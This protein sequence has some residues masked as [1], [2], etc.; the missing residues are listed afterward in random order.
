MADRDSTAL[1][2]LYSRHGQALFSYLLR[3]AGDRGVAEEILQDTLLAAWR[4]AG[5]FEGRSAV[6][7]WLFGI[8]RRQTHNRLRGKRLEWADL[9][10]AADMSSGDPGPEAAAL[11]GA[12][13]EAI[14]AAMGRI[15]SVH[16]EVLGLAFV[17][18]M[19]Y[20]EIAKI[21]AIPVGTVKSR[22]SHARR[23]LAAE[24]KEKR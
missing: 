19:A 21:L 16:A 1:A 24:L 7:T 10:E 17:D 14:V 12:D 4:S 20:V 15:S 18:G 11:A 5:G 13:R 23:A 6:R 2:T 3:L 8:G 22:L 9:T